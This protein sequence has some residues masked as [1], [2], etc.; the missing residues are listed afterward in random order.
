MA[1]TSRS[2]RPSAIHFADSHRA[3]QTIKSTC[4][5]RKAVALI[6][7]LRDEPMKRTT[8]FAGYAFTFVAP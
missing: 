1:G 4:L 2:R 6:F 7:L 5:S 3:R 8:W